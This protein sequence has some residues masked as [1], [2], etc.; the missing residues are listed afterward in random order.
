MSIDASHLKFQHYR[1]GVYDEPAC[2]ATDLGHAVLAVGYAI[3][4]GQDCYI[5]KNS[6]GSTWGTGG[7]ILMSP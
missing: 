3:K 6:W 5:V 4:D 7:Y 1:E 2:S